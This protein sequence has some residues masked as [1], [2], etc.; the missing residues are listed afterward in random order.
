MKIYN[1][2]T[3]TESR[4]PVSIFSLDIFENFLIIA[5]TNGD[6][7]LYKD[8]YTIYKTVRKHAGAVLCVRFNQHGSLIAS[9]GDDGAVIVYDIDLN[10]INF[11]KFHSGDV[12]NVFWTNKYLISVGHDGCIIFYDEKHFNVIA[13]IKSHE[14]KITGIGGNKKN[15]FICTQGDDGIV[16]YKD[17]SVYKKIPPNEGVILESFFSRMSWS[18]DGSIFSCGLSFNQKVNSI[19]IYNLE[20]E[21]KYSLLGHVAPCEV[22]CFNP[23]TF[24]NGVKQYYILAVGSQDLSISLWTTLS[25]YPFLLIKNVCEM[26]ILDLAWSLDGTNLYYCSYDGTVGKLEFDLKE[27]GNI[28]TVEHTTENS[29][30]F[31]TLLNA[32]LYDK[33]I[34]KLINNRINNT[35]MIKKNINNLELPQISNQNK[36]H[37]E[38]NDKLY[39]E[40]FLHEKSEIKAKNKNFKHLNIPSEIKNIQYYINNE[41]NKSDV[42]FRYKSQNISMEEKLKKNN[43][44]IK[45]QDNDRNTK[46]SFFDESVFSSSDNFNYKKETPP[47]TYKSNDQYFDSLNPSLRNQHMQNYSEG[48]RQNFNPFHNNYEMHRRPFIPPPGH[49]NMEGMPMYPPYMHN[50]RMMHMQ[51][52]DLN[53]TMKPNFM[54]HTQ[55]NDIRTLRDHEQSRCDKI[56]EDKLQK[57]EPLNTEDVGLRKKDIIE[58]VENNEKCKTEP[59]L[60]VNEKSN[61]LPTKNEQP[62]LTTKVIKRKVVKPVLLD[63]K[64]EAPVEVSM[65]NY[66]Q[67]VRIENGVIEEFYKDFGDY[68]IELNSEKTKLTIKRCKKDFFEI[69]GKFN[70]LCASKRYICVY[71][72]NIEIYDLRT[73]TLVCPFIGAGSVIYMDICDTNL[74][75]LEGDGTVGIFD[76][77]R[78]SLL[79]TRV[80]RYETVVRIRF[81]KLYFIICEYKDSEYI[82]DKNTKLWYLLRK[83]WNDLSTTNI[84][85]EN[86]VDETIKKLENKFLINFKNKR[87]DKLKKITKKMI[88][89][90]MNI[91]LTDQ[92]ENI[93]KKVFIDL[94]KLG[95]KK[96]VIR[97]LEKLSKKFNLQ[98]FIVDV[99]KN[100]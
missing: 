90:L 87:H 43:N 2:F 89:I 50:N 7:D 8:K 4:K 68:S 67:S 47:S 31:L 21:S 100:M 27:L 65:F 17:H 41:N 98:Y 71:T 56:S 61:N 5:S 25:P 14:N 76:I 48:I 95:H 30:L 38:H 94:I 6:I 97:C 20:M 92:Y 59:E 58:Q 81:S 26:P 78:N 62:N 80:P 32:E 79:N 11:F 29:D 15:N 42:D 19:E 73:G 36:I 53:M 60:S 91:K 1:L 44:L 82:L 75:F 16:L 52:Y 57:L 64:K 39:K 54:Q 35:R 99:M 24:I 84:D 74:L 9:C 46:T 86:T 28:S 10:V 55:R 33:K 18:P 23:K 22:T 37:K 3:K 63:D 88:K 13:K 69:Y 66:K 83:D 93:I 96:F 77:K 70:F 72:T 34:Q 85:Y 12:T 40:S 51:N 45:I 49:F